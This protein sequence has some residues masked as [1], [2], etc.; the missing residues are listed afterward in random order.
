MRVIARSVGAQQIAGNV[1]RV[2][3][4]MPLPKGGK[5]I[6]VHGEVHIIGEEDQPTNRFMAWGMS[7]VLVPI[8]DPET[9][10]TFNALW[11]NVV[12]KAADPTLVAATNLLDFDWDTAN[13][14][15][16]IEPGE[17]D[18]DALL[19]LTQGQKEFIPPRL[20]WM[21]WAKGRQGGFIAGTPDDYLPSD[22]KTYRSKR[23]L[24]ADVPSALMIAVS[25]PVL[26]EVELLAANTTPAS[27]AQWYQLQN[28]DE[29]MRD[30]AKMQAGLTDAGAI[31]PYFDATALIADLVARDMLDESGTL[32]NSVSWTT[33]VTATW[34]LDFP[35]NSLPKTLDGR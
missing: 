26:D 24:V 29:T 35:G 34:L 3:V 22:F 5:L 6:S 33:L 8:P 19:G 21:S 31:S 30:F 7:G 27:S 4:S 32:F 14:G 23:A 13:T 2:V 12:V 10:I 15:P 28:M 18:I 11:D 25:S 20:S 16:E 17:M 1:D 9:A